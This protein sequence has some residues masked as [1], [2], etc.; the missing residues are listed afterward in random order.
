MNRK[1][2][3]TWVLLSAGCA[4]VGTEWN[5]RDVCS[6]FTRLYHITS[7][8]GW[9][10]LPDRSIQLSPGHMYVVPAYMRHTNRCDKEMGHYYLHVYEHDNGDPLLLTDNWRFPDELPC[11]TMCEGA[12]RQLVDANPDVSLYNTNPKHYD[13]KMSFTGMLERSERIPMP[14]RLFNNA[15]ISIIMSQWVMAG[16]HIGEIGSKRVARARS[17]ISKHLNENISLDRLAENL[18]MSKHHFCHLFKAE[19]GQTPVNYIRFLRMRKAQ[20]ELTHTDRLVKEIAFSL[21]Y[22]DC[23]YFI[24]TFKKETGMTPSTYR[25]HILMQNDSNP[26]PRAGR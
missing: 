22:E 12:F 18:R 20:M 19:T 21:G 2:I 10:I 11:N 4:T 25:R 13:T 6:P 9:L 26:T 16:T 8:S 15:L 14:A 17:F 3:P 24:R 5:Y 1:G 23:N 7:G